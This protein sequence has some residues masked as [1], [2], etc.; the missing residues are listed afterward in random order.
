MSDMRHLD[1]ATALRQLWDY[2]DGELTAD[3]MAQI[4]E[5]MLRC[6]DCL[7][8]VRFGELFLQAIRKTRAEDPMP[9]H[10]R[11]RVEEMLSNEQ[12]REL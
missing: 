8:H 11:L 3:R 5:H 2:L 12:A 7:Q 6:A 1:C 4:R 10:L 9:P